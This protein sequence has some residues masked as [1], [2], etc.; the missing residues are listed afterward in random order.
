M[1]S[2]NTVLRVLCIL[3][4][5]Q[6][7]VTGVSASDMMFRYNAAHTGDYSP[8]AGTTGTTVSL[9]WNYTTGDAIYSSPAVANGIVYIAS[10]DHNLYAL[11]ATTGALKW[12]YTIGELKVVGQPNPAVANGIVYMGAHPGN[13]YAFNATTGG[14]IWNYTVGGGF[15]S[16]PTIADGEL[17]FGNSN[18]LYKFDAT[19]GALIRNYSVFS[20]VCSSPAVA[21]GVVY[22]GSYDGKYYAF[23][24]S[25]GALKWSYGNGSASYSSP[26]IVNGVVY[27]GG[28]YD[29][30]VYAIN[31]TTGVPKWNY[32]AGDTVM[33][34]PAVVNGIVYIGS[35]NDTIGYGMVN[36]LNATTGEKLWNFSSRGSFFSSPAI[37]NGVVYI[38]S[39]DNNIYALNAT[40]GVKLWNFTTGNGVTSSPAVANG[41]V[42]V[43]SH[44]GKVYALN[45]NGGTGGTPPSASFTGTPLS[46]TAPLTVQFNDTS[47]GSPTAWNWTFGDGSLVNVTVKNPVHTY[48]TAGNYTVSLN[49]TNAVGYNSTRKAGYIAVTSSETKIGVF[50]N[51]THLFYLDYNGN[52]VWNGAV[53]DRQYNFGISGDIPVSGDWNLDGKTDIGVFRN[54]THQFYLDYNGN[55]VWNGASVDK[56]YNFGI[57]GDIPVSGDW[58][59]DGKTEIGVFRPSTHLF[60]LD[61]N[62]NGVWNGASVDRQYNFGIS[63]D[64]PV[65]GDWNNDGKYEIGVFRNSTHLFYLDYNGNGAWNG[66]AVDR[67]YNFGITGDIP[68]AGDWKGDG[69]AEIG[70]F[71]PSTHLFYLDYN[72]NGAWNNASVDRSYNF[73]ITGDKPV[74]GK[75]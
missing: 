28:T 7:L 54:L 1:N 48:L 37:A 26:T 50:R 25:T 53:T 13:V 11:D 47:T 73:G 56:Q 61:Y 69:S 55:G 5:M 72:G 59:S 43:G 12:N 15:E 24:T 32:T 58:T 18:R 22:V 35:D 21:N 75:W 64:L 52:G 30:Q 38:G 60:Y 49:V 17:Y 39:F 36:A 9:L 20:G 31:A 23:D 66:A 16:S 57:T 51:S 29:G 2:R 62:G 6:L 46:G 41:V 45:T 10:E 44:D 74:T 63:G 40:T 42:Y 34:S 14:L 71:R 70:V 67:S 3:G 19:T 8:A 27:V 33:N 65:S 4:F 68:V